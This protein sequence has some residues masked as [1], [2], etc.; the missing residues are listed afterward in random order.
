[1]KYKRFFLTEKLLL[2]ENIQM[3]AEFSLVIMEK[4]E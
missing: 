4:R 2:H 1:M 3:W